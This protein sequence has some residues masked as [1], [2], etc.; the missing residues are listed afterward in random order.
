MA[1][2]LGSLDYVMLRAADVAA[3]VAVYRDT[4]DAVPIE[5]AY[6]RWARIRLANV[7]LGIHVDE[8]FD[9]R[10]ELPSGA[11]LAFRVHD[12]ASLRAALD[13]AGFTTGAYEVI[14][15]G[16]RVDLRDPC[17]NALAAIQWGGRIEDLPGGAG[18]DAPA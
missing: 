18:S 4:L 14:P 6:P 13:A 8:G 9:G 7:D 1:A 17:G 10:S 3:L 11:V 2:R 15:G 5:E 16:V 12:I